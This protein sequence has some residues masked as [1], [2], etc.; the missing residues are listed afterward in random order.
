MFIEWSSTKF[1]FCSDNKSKMAAS[2]GVGMKGKVFYESSS[3]YYDNWV[4]TSAGGLL[5]PDGI[6]LPVVECFGNDMVY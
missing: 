5:V 1:Y 6:I 3:F 2:A 4:D